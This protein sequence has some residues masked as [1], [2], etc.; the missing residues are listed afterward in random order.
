MNSTTFVLF[1]KYCLIM[2]Q[3]GSKDLSCDFQLNYIISYF[4]PTF[5]TSCIGPKINVIERE[6]ISIFEVHLNKTLVA[7]HC[8]H[9]RG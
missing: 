7:L 8:M 6:K 9:G 2:D 4:L 5:T 3:L 1:G